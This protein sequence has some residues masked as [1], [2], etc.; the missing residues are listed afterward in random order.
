MLVS[1]LQCKRQRLAPIT[2]NY[3][4]QDVSNANVE[5]TRDIYFHLCVYIWV[6]YV[7]IHTYELCLC[8]FNHTIHIIVY[9]GIFILIYN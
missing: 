3:P 1:I 9:S 5:R 4:V 6:L 2:E 7:H 8:N